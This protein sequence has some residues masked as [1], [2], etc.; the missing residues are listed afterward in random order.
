[1]DSSGIFYDCGSE[2]NQRDLIRLNGNALLA[3][4]PRPVVGH[5]RK[6]GIRPERLLFGC[7][8]KLPKRVVRVFHSILALA[9][10]WILRD[11]PFGE[12]KWLVVGNGEHGRKERLAG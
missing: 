9:F 10:I 12:S 8:E 1:M 6:N 4:N 7:L 11:A 3:I 5:Y 2:N